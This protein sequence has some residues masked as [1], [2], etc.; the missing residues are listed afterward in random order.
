MWAAEQA[1]RWGLVGN[2]VS[3]PVAKWLGER[4]AEPHRY[5]YYL[6]AKDRRMAPEHGV[7][8]ERFTIP[9]SRD[10]EDVNCFWWSCVLQ[11]A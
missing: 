7:G 9:S 8:A 3:V 4:L 6:G 11:S 10:W 5:K 2:A 1:A